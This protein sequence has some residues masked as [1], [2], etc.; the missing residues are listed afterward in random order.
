LTKR[1]IPER[2][3]FSTSGI[4]YCLN[5]LVENDYFKHFKKKFDYIYVLTLQGIVEKVTLTSRFL[6]RK[7][8]QYEALMAEVGG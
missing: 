5:D 6:K 7:L 2:R 1:E 4:N 3:G 8:A